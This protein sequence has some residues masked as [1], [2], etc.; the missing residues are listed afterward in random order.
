[1]KK[2]YNIFIVLGISLMASIL[3]PAEKAG[4]STLSPSVRSEIA[5]LTGAKTNSITSKFK[6]GTKKTE[7]KNDGSKDKNN[8]GRSAD[9]PFELKSAWLSDQDIIL[10][11][12]APKNL[13]GLKEAVDVSDPRSVAAYWVLSVNRLTE[14]Y[15]DGMSMMKYLFAD[16]EPYGRGFT[17]GGVSGKAG[18]DSYFNDRLKDKNYKWLPAAYFEGG[19]RKNNFTPS[20]PLTIELYYNDTNTNAINSQT[21]DTLGRLNIVYWVKSHAGGNQV[22]I[23]LSRFEGTDRWYVTSGTSSTALFYQQ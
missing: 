12:P 10:E 15:D 2:K 7:R 1:M 20:K 19:S 8:S 6:N 21:F 23:T 3:F 11:D 9:E 14:N 16:I 4:A 13:K 17:E 22:N 5:A 18:W